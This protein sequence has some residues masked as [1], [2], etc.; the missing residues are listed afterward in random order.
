MRNEAVKS[1]SSPTLC[2]SF[3]QNKSS[4]NEKRKNHHLYVLIDC[5]QKKKDHD[6]LFPIRIEINPIRGSI[7]VIQSY[8]LI[9][10]VVFFS[11]SILLPEIELSVGLWAW[12]SL[13]LF[14]S[15]YSKKIP[16][17]NFVLN[18]VEWTIHS[19]RRLSAEC[20][21]FSKKNKTTFESKTL[22][23]NVTVNDV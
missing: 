9:F 12:E 10:L 3:L 8:R 5:I 13:T 16:K 21:G 22:C 4:R 6:N 1:D 2:D 23:W 18:G 11:F 19:N 17:A 14:V 7:D 15:Y 20:N